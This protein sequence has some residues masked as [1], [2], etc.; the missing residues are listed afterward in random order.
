MALYFNKKL[1]LINLP[2]TEIPRLLKKKGIDEHMMVLLEI[3][4]LLLIIFNSFIFTFI[5][6]PTSLKETMQKREKKAA[7]QNSWYLLTYWVSETAIL[8][9]HPYW[10]LWSLSTSKL[11]ATSKYFSPLFNSIYLTFNCLSFLDILTS[12][13]EKIS[14]SSAACGSDSTRARISTVYGWLIL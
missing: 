4:H 7:F 2:N 8:Q 12:C 1:R 6:Q 13:L 9:T 11:T 10:Y 3:K 5:L 14:V